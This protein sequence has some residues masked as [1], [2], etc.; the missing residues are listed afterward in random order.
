TGL[1]TT[2][3]VPGTTGWPISTIRYLLPAVGAATVAVAL[4]TR[5]PPPIGQLAMAFLVVALG[6][7]VVADARL[8]LP[9]TPTA[10]TLLAG[11]LAGILVLGAFVVVGRSMR[12][13]ALRRRPSEGRPKPVRS[14]ALA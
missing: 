6:W 10:R 9:Y 5:A 13:R 2:R 4:L 7:S 14:G 1:P 3:G 11:A 8:G 12:V